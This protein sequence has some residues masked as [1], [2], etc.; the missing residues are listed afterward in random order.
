MSMPTVGDNELAS[1]EVVEGGACV[2]R[3]PQLPGSGFPRAWAVTGAVRADNVYI[4]L[5]LYSC[6]KPSSMIYCM[7]Y[8]ICRG[9]S[10]S[11]RTSSLWDTM[12]TR[13]WRLPNV[14]FGEV[15]RTGLGKK[16]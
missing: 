10:P 1:S 7:S 5:L 8:K 14:W 16:T 2:G 15:T 3:L 13:R 11:E 4:F 9:C 6:I 12:T